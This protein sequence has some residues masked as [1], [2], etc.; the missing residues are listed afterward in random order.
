MEEID[1]E[2]MT[3]EEVRDFT[4]KEYPAITGVE[5]M[6]KEALVAAIQKARAEAVKETDKKEVAAKGQNEK[7]ELKKQIRLLR[8]EKEKLL[9]EKDKKALARVRKKIKKLKR[10]TQRTAGQ[11]V[12][13]KAKS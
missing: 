7:Q 4:L 10:L 12:P 13:A 3:V 2:K 8:S 1:L 11:P 9:Q 5:A 6:E